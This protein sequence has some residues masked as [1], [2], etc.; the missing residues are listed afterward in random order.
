M[1]GKGNIGGRK[2]R[3]QGNRRGRAMKRWG[4]GVEERRGTEEKEGEERERETKEKIR[5][6]PGR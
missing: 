2:E 4:G 6:G 1:R 3:R 5:N